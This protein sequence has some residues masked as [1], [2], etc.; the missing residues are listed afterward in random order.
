MIIFELIPIRQCCGTGTVTG[1]TGTATFGLSGTGTGMHSGS[2]SGRT[3]KVEKVEKYNKGA[4][5]INSQ[6]N[7]LFEKLC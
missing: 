6:L 7:F 1:T 5:N 3:I 4:S 2:G